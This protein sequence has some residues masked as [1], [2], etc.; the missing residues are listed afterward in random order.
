MDWTDRKIFAWTNYFGYKDRPSRWLDPRQLHANSA[1][2]GLRQRPTIGDFFYGAAPAARP[3]ARFTTMIRHQLD[4]GIG[5]IAS[6]PT[7]TTCCAS[8]AGRWEALSN[9]D[10]EVSCQ[11]RSFV[12]AEP[13]VGHLVIGDYGLN[14]LSRW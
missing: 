7:T 3:S 13:A 1:A 2:L 5:S 12:S 8:T 10:E 11:S 14:F 6:I 4:S 9:I